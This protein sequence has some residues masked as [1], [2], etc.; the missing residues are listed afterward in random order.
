M[1]LKE[2]ATTYAAFP[3]SQLR[4]CLVYPV[5]PKRALIPRGITDTIKTNNKFWLNMYRHHIHMCM[6]FY[7]CDFHYS[8]LMSILLFLYLLVETFFWYSGCICD[9]KVHI[10]LQA[11]SKME[12]KSH[13]YNGLW[14]KIHARCLKPFFF[15]HQ[16]SSWKECLAEAPREELFPHKKVPCFPCSTFPATSLYEKAF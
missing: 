11:C 3:F 7:V 14:H 8:Y 15:C 16:A 6:H 1:T 13:S 4:E 9:A 12:A 10:K 2:R 5:S